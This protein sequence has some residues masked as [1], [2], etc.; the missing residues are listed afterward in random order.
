MHF[1]RLFESSWSSDQM[2]G[3]YQKSME[4]ISSACRPLMEQDPSRSNVIDSRT[5]SDATIGLADGLTVPFALTA[6][7]SALG[8]PRVVVYGGLAELFAG[9]ISMG[10]GGYLGGKYEALVTKFHPTACKS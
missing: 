5:I 2:A 9:A 7:L 6:G 8:N 10:L 3:G 4:D 1:Q